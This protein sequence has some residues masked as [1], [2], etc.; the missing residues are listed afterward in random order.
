MKGLSA[1]TDLFVVTLGLREYCF[2]LTKDISKF[3]NSIDA[4]PIARHMQR[5]V[6]RQGDQIAEPKI[7]RTTTIN[8]GD[9]PAGCISIAAARETADMFGNESQVAWSLKNRTYVDDVSGANSL[10]EL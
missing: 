7:Y 3:Y 8:F 2:A 6:W 1:L 5:V 9:K 10:E 4:D